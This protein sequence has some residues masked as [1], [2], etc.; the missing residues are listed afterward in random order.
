MSGGWTSPFIRRFVQPLTEGTEPQ[1]PPV[2]RPGYAVHDSATGFGP[3]GL[4]WH[5]IKGEGEKIEE[6]DTWICSPIHADAMTASDK[7]TD[8]GLL[9]RFQN[10]AGRWREWSMPMELLKGSGEELRGELL[11]LGV[12]INP[13]QHRLL[14]DYLMR[15]TPERRVLAATQTGWHSAGKVFV[16]PHRIIGASDVR[17]QSGHAQHDEF[18]TAGT[19]EG[20]RAEISARCIGNPM[21]NL[22][23]SGALAGPLLDKVNRISGGIHL[24]GDSSTGK[25]TALSVAASVW[26]GPDFIRTWRATSNGLEGVAAALNDTAL[27]LDEISE[28]DPAEV[29]AIIY[30]I[31]NGT[32]KSRADRTGASRPPKRWR[33]MLL[34]SGERTITATM[35]EGGRRRKA[36]QLVRLLDIPCRRSFGL[37]DV[38][39]EQPNGRAL[40]DK[41]RTESAHHFGHAGPAFV[42]ALIEDDSGDLGELL[43][44]IQSREEFASESELEGRAASALALVAAAGELATYFGITGWQE[45]AAIKAVATAYQAWKGYQGQGQTESLQILEAVGSFIDRH[46]DSRF[47]D[48]SHNESVK[49]SAGRAGWFRTKGDARIYMFTPDGL[50]EAGGGFDINR[51]LDAL[52]E[53]GWIVERDNT[54]GKRS[55]K[56]KVNGE[57]KSLYYIVPQEVEE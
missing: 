27:I 50:K 51:I 11:D 42:Q 23:V 41:L 36:G 25:S 10:A 5:D 26:G 35:A 40:S 52:D 3:S 56:T 45:G 37:F 30:S 22:A 15:Q 12:R 17:F 9:L 18:V 19:L 24:V 21:L 43:A 8:H 32:G 55:K 20:W 6:I 14:N 2:K 48:F 4:Y 16:L 44:N 29:G 13:R 7:D 33:V 31:G 53:A 34:S 28:A 54:G 47:T 46:G 1:D 38:L 49:V 57:T 39:H